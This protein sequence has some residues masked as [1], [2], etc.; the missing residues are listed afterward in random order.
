MTVQTVK[1][2]RERER[3]TER[4]FFC[5]DDRGS[6][7]PLNVDIYLP[8]HTASNPTRQYH[9]LI[10]TVQFIWKLYTPKE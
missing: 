5:P 6:R 9:S 10:N 8:D 3:Q 1:T 2:E 4:V 7:I